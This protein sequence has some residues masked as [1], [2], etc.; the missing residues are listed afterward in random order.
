MPTFNYIA[1]DSAGT[2]TAGSIEAQDR[3][4]A[5]QRLARRGLTPLSLNSPDAPAGAK[6]SADVL[7]SEPAQ[8]A[9]DHPALHKKRALG[10]HP[11]AKSF[12]EKLYSLLT[13][14]LPAG[15]AIK[16][17]GQRV[18]DPALRA[19]TTRI[20]RDLS[21]GLTLANAMARFPD[22]FDKAD[23]HLVEAGEATGTLTP[24]VKRLLEYGE[25][26]D[27]LRSKI[28][29]SMAYPIFIICMACGVIALFIFYLM[30]LL[31]DMMGRLG[32]EMNTTTRILVALSKAIIYGGPLLAAASVAAFFSIKNWRTTDAGLRATDSKL[33]RLPLV[34]AIV[35]NIE[36]ART[37]ALISTLMENGLNTPDALRLSERA[38][39]NA[40]VRER[41]SAARTLISDGASFTNSFK[42]HEVLP[43]IDLDI[44]AVGESTG[45]LP[46][47]FR[48][49]AET[50]EKLLDGAI[51]RFIVVLSS[52][53]LGAAVAIVFLCLV[54]IVLTILSVSQSAA[55]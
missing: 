46:A 3:R 28:F 4:Q 52:G 13:S 45:T 53:V 27:A 49:V 30:P 51:R 18:N 38:S 44:I 37:C 50:H 19:L 36:S 39:G 5:A 15:D 9:D 1:K 8:T 43:Q 33:L 54:S 25:S 26:R 34:G 47:A 17:L 2:Q 11:T 21:E 29:A 48:Q 12:L 16:L 42:R 20:W 22:V 31:Q 23:V 40:I 35:S 32:G 7:D 41:I 10:T 6:K 14:G 55:Q 24:V